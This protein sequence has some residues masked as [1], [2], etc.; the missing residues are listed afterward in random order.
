M[1]GAEEPGQQGGVQEGETRGGGA[2]EQHK[3]SVAGL[4]CLGEL[5]HQ[6]GVGHLQVTSAG[7]EKTK[8]VHQVSQKYK[9]VRAETEQ[10][11]GVKDKALE[12]G[13]EGSAQHRWVRS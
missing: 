9:V 2:G 5:L 1:A 13:G 7:G 8:A 11:D 4:G 12:E 3:V 6:A 10:E